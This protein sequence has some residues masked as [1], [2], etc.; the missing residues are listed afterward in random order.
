[1]KANL[2]K[3]YHEVTFTND[4]EITMFSR[5]LPPKNIL[6]AIKNIVGTWNLVKVTTF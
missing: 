5:F 4:Q 3:A 2:T 6:F 1:M